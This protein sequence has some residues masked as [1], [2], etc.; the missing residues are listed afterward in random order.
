MLKGTLRVCRAARSSARIA[1]FVFCKSVLSG[2]F[3]RLIFLLITVLK[4]QVFSNS[5]DQVIDLGISRGYTF[6]Y[7]K[8]REV[9]ESG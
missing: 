9:W 7:R 3:I 4:Y 1:L 8:V 2:L 6:K 5:F